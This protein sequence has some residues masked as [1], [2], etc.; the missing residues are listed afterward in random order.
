[1]S[2][3]LE[4]FRMPS[5]GADMAAGRLVQWFKAPGDPLRR[6]DIIAEVDTDKGAIDIE[7]FTDGVLAEILVH[8]GERV[9]VGTALAR[10]QRAGV[11]AAAAP[12][13]AP[14]PAP[15][16]PASPA[17]APPSAE[18]RIQVSPVARRLA[19]EWGVDLTGVQG[20]GPGGAITVAD[21]E[22][23]AG[24]KAETPA[25]RMRR[26]VGA[27]MARS[28]REIPHYYLSTTVDLG[29]AVEWLAERNRGRPPAERLLLG[30]LPLK[31]IALAL[32]E[33]PDFNAWYENGAVVPKPAI[34][35][36]VAIA[37]R[38]AGLVAPA[39]HDTDRQDLETLMRSLH[40]LV[41]RARGGAL[42]SSE[43][44]DGTITLTS[45]GER[46][47]DAVTGVIYPPQV[48]LVGFGR[49]AQR[50]WV[51]GGAVVPRPLV[52]ATLAGDHRAS[53]G[54][55]GGLFLARVEQLL[56]EPGAL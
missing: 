54:H 30:V 42:R 43:L 7:V 50:P 37:L 27:A 41:D 36:G 47:V 35:V 20:S 6:G 52:T 33:F 48:A 38:D 56:Q 39:I 53:D 26:A 12:A 16:A 31:A 44:S 22:A 18:P 45:L 34:N 3:Q 1:M 49:V 9:P 25:A 14:A 23:A 11:A 40:D 46:G 10:I 21:V 24:G 32:R 5:L 19:G 51:V 15:P 29:S 13:A 28:K 2:D 17:P 8:E 55:R 4:E